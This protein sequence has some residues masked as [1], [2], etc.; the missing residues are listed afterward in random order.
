MSSTDHQ[1]AAAMAA[2]NIQD[3]SSV[4]DE[5]KTDDS[6]FATADGRS[7]STVEREALDRLF[8]QVSKEKLQ[9]LEVIEMPKELKNV[10]LYD[11]QK[12]G[13]SWLFH[14]EM[15]N[16]LPVWWENAPNNAGTAKLQYRCTVTQESRMDP[17]RPVKG[18]I[19]ADSMGLGKTLQVRNDIAKILMYATRNTFLHVHG[20]GQT[21]RLLALSLLIQEMDAL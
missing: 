20:L 3:V 16:V 7:S 17:P 6:F 4:S 12:Q 14:N 19:L 8:E 5:K 9:G 15:S 10:K 2:L 11:H 13:I 21:C 18:S 1:V